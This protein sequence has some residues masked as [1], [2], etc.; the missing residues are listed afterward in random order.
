MLC[1]SLDKDLHGCHLLGSNQV[2]ISGLAVNHPEQFN[3]YKP[4][5]RH[6][7]RFSMNALPI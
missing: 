1:F 7:S 2:A 4:T 3:H 5:V 6:K